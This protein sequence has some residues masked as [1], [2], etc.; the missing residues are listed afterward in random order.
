M[1]ISLFS[2]IRP[3]YLQRPLSR[4][5][6]CALALTLTA[7]L[8]GCQPDTQ[9][10]TDA[11]STTEQAAA[12]QPAKGDTPPPARATA[13]QSCDAQ[14]H[15]GLIGQSATGRDFDGLAPRVRVIGPK[16]PVTKDYRPN[17]LN[18]TYDESGRITRVYCG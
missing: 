4:L 5:L 1:T 8:S 14:A 16:Q 18:I 11:Q 10:A 9:P 3:A 12:D 13:N 6:L 15:A 17:R 7:A 2:A